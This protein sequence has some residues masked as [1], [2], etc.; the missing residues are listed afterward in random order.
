LGVSLT[1]CPKCPLPEKKKAAAFTAGC[2]IT[3]AF[4]TIQKKSIWIIVIS[5][6]VITFAVQKINQ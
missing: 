6:F 1:F 3:K 2:L 4:S 5:K